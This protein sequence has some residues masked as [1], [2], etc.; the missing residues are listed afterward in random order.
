MQ[1]DKI[2]TECCLEFLLTFSCTY[3]FVKLNN[4]FT[5]QSTVDHKVLIGP[6]LRVL[7]TSAVL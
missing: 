5:V 6:D 3:W 4:Q 2:R 1:E 7:W